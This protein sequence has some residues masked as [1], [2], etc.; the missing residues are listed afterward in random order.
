[1]SG[2]ETITGL[3]QASVANTQARLQCLIAPSSGNPHGRAV[4]LAG[5]S[6]DRE[7][8]LIGPLQ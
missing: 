4:P 8:A 2:I 5:R 6:Q 1:M 7:K 3:E